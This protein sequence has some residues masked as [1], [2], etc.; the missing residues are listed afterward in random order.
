MLMATGVTFAFFRAARARER[1]DLERR[2]Q[3]R[4]VRPGSARSERT[5]RAA[6]VRTIRIE[7]NALTQLLDHRLGETSVGARDARLCAREAFVDAANERR[8]VVAFDVGMRAY[9][10]LGI[11]D[12]RSRIE[13]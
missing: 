2:A 12:E 10:L 6:Q 4:L 9:Y 13:G 7:A 3:H 8:A 1:A 5:R 11:H